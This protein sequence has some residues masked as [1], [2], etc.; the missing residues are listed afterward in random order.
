MKTIS[1]LFLVCIALV[2]TSNES[3]AQASDSSSRSSDTSG[4]AR[5]KLI[6]DGNFELED[7]DRTYR[8]SLYYYFESNGDF[9]NLESHVFYPPPFQLIMNDRNE[10]KHDF[11]EEAGTL[12]IWVRKP[13]NNQQIERDLRRKLATVAVERHDV[14]ILE[15]K[16][17]Y[18]ISV[19]PLNSAVFEFTKNNKISSQVEGAEITDGDIAV[20][21]HEFSDHEARKHIEDLV[22]DV[23]QLRFRYSFS[24]VSDEECTAKSETQGVQDIDLFKTVKGKGGE[25]LV[26]RSQAVDIADELDARKI[27][28]IRCADSGAL[29]DLTDILMKELENQETRQ[30]ASWEELGK[31]I[32]F[33]LNS[34]KAD[35]VTKLRNIDKSVERDQALNAALEATSAANSTAIEGDLKY[36]GVELA[37]S[38]A[39]T[40]SESKAGARKMFTDAL[41][42]MGISVEWDGKKFIPKSV[43]VHSVSDLEAKWDRSVEFK[44]KVPKGLE[45]RDSFL[46]TKIDR[47]V[48]TSGKER[49]KINHRIAKIETMVNGITE[50]LTSEEETTDDIRKIIQEENDR[51]LI[52]TGKDKHVQIGATGKRSLTNEKGDTE[53]ERFD[54]NFQATRDVEI[55]G[56]DDLHVNAE[57]EVRINAED[58]NLNASDDVFINSQDRLNFRGRKIHFNSEPHITVGM[59]HYILRRGKSHKDDHNFYRALGR[60][61]RIAI[62][63]SFYRNC[64]KEI[65]NPFTPEV[66]IVR[67]GPNGGEDD[68]WI[69]RVENWKERSTD[70]RKLNVRVIFM[71]GFGVSKDPTNRKPAKTG[72]LL[73][74]DRSW[75]RG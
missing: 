58:I 45:S 32:A 29:A 13:T 30:V 40:S 75:C 25:G 54:L 22:K 65:S 18:R 36:L 51:I 63:G 38:F 47:T 70:C 61:D 7:N 41:R 31:M 37:A 48:M 56:D 52:G 16:V 57:D 12:T 35:V 67:A 2:L 46:L 6:N 62:V 34:F 39:D 60:S 1:L 24:A 64:K 15:G 53:T 10:V 44:F 14:K 73:T 59:C 66:H 4:P 9:S 68:E 26:T 42:K 27:F 3:V 11:D 43:D 69:L 17:P 19:L 49:K 20:H 74:L 21:F 23:T 5:P 8:Y 50:R 72:R 28:T 71:D 33:D 55:S